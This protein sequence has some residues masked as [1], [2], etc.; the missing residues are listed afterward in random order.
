MMT[1]KDYH[2]DVEIDQEAG[3]LCGHVIDIKDVITFQGA[4]VEETYQAFKDSVDDYLA[5]C[6]ERGEE[7]AKPFSGKLPFRTTPEIHRRI[8]LASK[9]RQM[10]MNA[11]ME[12]TLAKAADDNLQERSRPAQAPRLG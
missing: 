2:A 3:V 7:P 9:A 1:Y 5:F 8:Y 6:A 11:W 4:T 10:S 12:A